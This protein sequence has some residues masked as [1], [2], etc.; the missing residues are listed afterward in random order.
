MG[1][2]PPTS[3]RFQKLCQWHHFAEID[4]PWSF[5]SC[6]CPLFSL[7]LKPK[8]PCFFHDLSSFFKTPQASYCVAWPSLWV[9]LTFPPDEVFPPCLLVRQEGHTPGGLA[10]QGGAR[11]VTPSHSWWD[12]LIV[13]LREV[14]APVKFSTLKKATTFLL[15]SNRYLVGT[16]SGIM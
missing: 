2:K 9:S 12:W 7:S 14:S 15:I 4:S 10:S 8:Q 13:W 3:F 11:D 5:V 16:N 6:G 1:A